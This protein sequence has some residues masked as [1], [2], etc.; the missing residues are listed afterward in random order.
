MAFL[1]PGSQVTQLGRGFAAY[2]KDGIDHIKFT[3]HPILVRQVARATRYSKNHG[4][5]LPATAFWSKAADVYDDNVKL[6]AREH[7][8]KPLLALLRRDEE[9]DRTHPAILQPAPSAP[10]PVLIMPT[11]PIATVP[12]Q[13]PQ[14]INDVAVPEPA[15]VVC[16]GLG[17]L[18]VFVVG[19]KRS[20]ARC[21]P[22]H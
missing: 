13:R 19:W 9:Y 4:G 5:D 15:S 21:M 12:L 7:Q 22:A 16:L 17:L 6:F 11:G 3:S 14:A 1:P 2:E 18:V 8:C 10:L 20:F